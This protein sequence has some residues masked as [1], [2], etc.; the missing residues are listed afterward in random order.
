MK[1]SSNFSIRFTSLCIGI[2][3]FFSTHFISA[4]PS[5]CD[6]F[7]CHKNVNLTIQR[8]EI[9]PIDLSD[10]LVNG[11]CPD[12]NY[13]LTI[14]KDG[15]YLPLTEIS[16]HFPAEFNYNIFDV[17]LHQ[18]CNGTVNLSFIDCDTNEPPQKGVNKFSELLCLEFSNYK[19]IPF[20][21]PEHVS[22][23][24]ENKKILAYDWAKCGPVELKIVREITNPGGCAYDFGAKYYRT[25]STSWP[26]KK[27]YFFMDSVTY[28]K[29][30]IDSFL[31]LPNFDNVQN[32][33]FDFEDKSWVRDKKNHPNGAETSLNFFDKWSC[34][35]VSKTYNDKILEINKVDSCHSLKI[36]EREWTV[37]D[38]CTGEILGYPQ[39]IHLIDIDDQEVPSIVC[40]SGIIEFV[41]PKS[42]LLNVNA[43][44]LGL[45]STD[46]C[47]INIYT[48]DRN[49]LDTFK[50]FTLSDTGIVHDIEV[51]VHDHKGNRASCM[52]K[53]LIKADL[54]LDVFDPSISQ[55]VKIYPNPFT[56]EL[57]IDTKEFRGPVQV[58]IFDVLG[59]QIWRSNILIESQ[60]PTSI[61]PSGLREGA[62]Y[63]LTLKNQDQ[64]SSARII[65]W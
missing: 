52:I 31:V 36:I 27:T 55:N 1:Q 9:R 41:L 62:V 2:F 43:N 59:K 48:F 4:Q 25:W 42:N 40:P 60:G 15:K 54:S 28:L 56:D 14:Y 3:F 23:V 47:G 53:I 35:N 24:I 50:T 30:R 6:D 26:D 44:E 13:R 34:S 21:V 65:K 16:Y 11:V 33:G 38:W 12:H 61:R 45:T 29:F 39:I 64:S 57:S 18:G 8:G 7:K 51:W 17:N 5:P 58:D 46:N 20:N 49:V 37:I 22:I 32:P 63:T 10:F 19:N